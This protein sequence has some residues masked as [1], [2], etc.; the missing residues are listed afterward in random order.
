MLVVV[1]M[2][3]QSTKSD[4]EKIIFSF[5]SKE[6]KN[7]SAIDEADDNDTDTDTD[8]NTNDN[9]GSNKDLV[10]IM[11]RKDSRFKNVS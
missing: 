11:G 4:C 10:M 9:N 1:V 5:G 7:R 3:K 8:T 6:C 2:V